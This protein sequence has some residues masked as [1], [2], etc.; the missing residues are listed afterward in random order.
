MT[1]STDGAWKSQA[2]TSALWRNKE[3]REIWAGK[4]RKM[5]GQRE[6]EEEKE[7]ERGGEKVALV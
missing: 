7:E 2:K 5:E 3:L 6:G 1:D 4:K